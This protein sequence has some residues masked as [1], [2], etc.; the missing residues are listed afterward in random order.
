MPRREKRAGSSTRTGPTKRVVVRHSDAASFDA[1]RAA[2]D[3]WMVRERPSGADSG[4]F[5]LDEGPFRVWER[6][7][8]EAENGDLTET[9]EFRL[10]TPLLAAPFGLF[11]GWAI[12]KRRFQTEAP[13]WA[14]PQRFDAQGAHAFTLLIAATMAAAYLGTLLSQTISFVADDFG[15]DRGTQGLVTGMTR[16]GALLSLLIVYLADRVGR[17]RML[18]SAG[19]GA[20]VFAVI[21]AASTNIWFFG[22]AELVSRGLTTG[23]GLLIGIFAAEEAP[24]GSR[25]WT[26]SILALFAGLG[27]GMVL[28]LIPL[29]D[30]STGGWRILF[31][32]AALAIPVILAL[33]RRLPESRRFTTMTE[34]K[35]EPAPIT[36]DIRRRFTMLAM[37]GFATSMFAAPSSNFQN[38]YL[39]DERGFSGTQIS[40]FSTVTSTPIGIGVAIF[41]PMADRRGRRI[42][43]AIGILAGVIFN[44]IR[45]GLGGPL[46]WIAG[47]LST[48]IGAAAIPALGVY[49][50]EMFPTSRRGLANGLLTLVAVV[51]SII[52][53]AFVGEMSERWSFGATFAI[54][55]IV[56]IL[57]TAILRWY[58]ETA[59][60]AL[61]EL[62]PHDSK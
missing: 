58:P 57:A 53:L 32:V 31:L 62:N 21:A 45:Y 34:R 49:G 8:D 7:V 50:P 19:L 26:A 27:S 17:R 40:L 14:P 59:Q 35:A 11:F 46:M 30:T 60:K 13:F 24:A 18:V 12:R 48:I 61:E 43:G 10:A 29:A 44:V 20:A 6:S 38:E 9:T 23:L 15:A 33:G 51:G 54:L 1:L 2:R 25:A 42:I 41:G 55:A 4:Y 56:P 52:G 28:W 36:S 39:R 5:T 22:S 37:V 3:D 16:I 47:T